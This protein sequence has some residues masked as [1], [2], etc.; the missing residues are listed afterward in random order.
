MSYSWVLDKYPVFEY[1]HTSCSRI[2]CLH[3]MH[4]VLLLLMFSHCGVARLFLQNFTKG[5]RHLTVAETKAFLQEG[6]S[7]GDGKIGW[8]GTRVWWA[9]GCRCC[10]VFSV[11]GEGKGTYSVSYR[12]RGGAGQ[13]IRHVCHAAWYL[14]FETLLKCMLWAELPHQISIH[15]Q[16]LF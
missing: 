13:R 9:L 4:F 16:F 7:D 6:D 15:S 2:V 11:S 10:I 1:A 14:K 12:L 5:A 3:E 8:E